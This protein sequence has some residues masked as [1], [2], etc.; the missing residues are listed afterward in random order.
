M[1]GISPP[2]GQISN[3]SSRP[4]ESCVNPSWSC[5]WGR[6][7]HHSSHV[8]Q[9][10]HFRS[11]T[12]S[13][14]NTGHG[15]NECS[16]PLPPP[17][18]ALTRLCSNHRCVKAYP[19]GK[20]PQ[21]LHGNYEAGRTPDGWLRKDRHP[22]RPPGRLP[23]RDHELHQPLAIDGKKFIQ[24]N[25]R[26]LEVLSCWRTKGHDQ[27]DQPRVELVDKAKQEKIDGVKSRL[28]NNYGYCDVCATD[29]LSFVA[30]IFARGHAKK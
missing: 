5:S 3:A 16:G 20:G 22:R 27:A 1:S 19:A 30:S 12:S 4:D 18:D 11:C 2:S 25:E 28:T 10:Q 17:R 13:R 7:R 29:V 15:Q 23:P 26:R 14:K 9:L 8:E 6:P 21:P 24:D